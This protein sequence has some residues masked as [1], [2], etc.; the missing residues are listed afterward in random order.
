MISSRP[1]LTSGR[2][3][4]VLGPYRLLQHVEL[5]RL[6]PHQLRVLV[7]HHLE[8][9]LIGVGQLNAGFVRLPVARVPVED[10]PLARHVARELER[11]QHDQLLGRRG[12]AE[13]LAER[14]G[15]QRRLQLVP[16]H[17]RHV[18]EQADAR[19]ERRR[20]GHDDGARIRELDLQWL[21]ADQ[22]RAG[23]GA[24]RARVVGRLE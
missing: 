3:G 16:R 19:P 22:Q 23:Q 6:Q 1:W 12:N 21:A 4:K 7:G 13:G 11:P 2:S 24:L 10:Q 5:A 9:E 15:L 8:D 17:D 18:V 20:V 14:A